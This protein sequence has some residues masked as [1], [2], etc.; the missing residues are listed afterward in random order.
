MKKLLILTIVIVLIIGSY[1]FYQNY[2]I[3]HAKIEVG[4]IDNLDLEVYSD[5]HLKDLIRSINGKLIDNS[6]IDTN[7]LGE[8]EITFEYINDEKIK[9][10]YSFNVNV[11]DTTKP[12][13]GSADAMTFLKG[14]KDTILERVFCADN[15]DKKPKCEIE[16]EYDLNVV[17]NYPI[18][19]KATDS[20]DNI[21]THDVI[22]KV[23][24]KATPT[25]QTITN[26][27]DI[28]AKFKD[29]KVGIDVSFYQG[30]IDFE[31][32]KNAGIDFVIIRLGFGKDGKN[33]LD[34]KFIRN[35][36][37]FNKLNI[38]VGIYFVS[39][40]T[41]EKEIKDEVKFILKNIKKY[42]VDLPIAFDWE[43]WRNFSQYNINLHTLNNLSKVFI[44][45]VKKKNYKGILYSSKNYLN[46][47]WYENTNPVWIAH[48]NE[49]ENYQNMHD[50]WQ[51]CDDGK[52]DG[53]EGFV[54]IDIMYGS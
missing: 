49:N 40:A 32:V 19:L 41:D 26:F 37:G 39:Y 15:Y 45:E 30:D 20:S 22:V 16:G 54:D 35:I 29:H 12:I 25:E 28:K 24:E 46:Y 33:E 10:K 43:H 17:S 18:A 14:S 34:D 21:S 50:M 13:I 6:K 44:D 36:E 53:I 51:L 9:V 48:Y 2:R 23:I 31:K 11:V 4:L 8:Q 7:K 3:K 38:P 47:A 52:I 1:F 5:I 42:D 27:S